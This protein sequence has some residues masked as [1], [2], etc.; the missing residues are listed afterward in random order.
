M[1]AA[2]APHVSSVRIKMALVKLP[3]FHAAL[4][5]MYMCFPVLGL[6][7]FGMGRYGSITGLNSSVC[8]G[9]CAAGYWCSEVRTRRAPVS[10]DGLMVDSG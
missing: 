8:S 2:F 7:T 10:S 5:G 3:A 1:Q 4:A 9:A 6:F